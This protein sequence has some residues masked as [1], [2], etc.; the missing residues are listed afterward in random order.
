MN[1]NVKTHGHVF[2]VP[3]HR[4]NRYFLFSY[5]VSFTAEVAVLH[6][7]LSRICWLQNY[8]LS[9]LLFMC[10]FHLLQRLKE[11]EDKF[12][13]ACANAKKRAK[14]K[15]EAKKQRRATHLKNMQARKDGRC[16]FFLMICRGS[17]GSR[18]KTGTLT[19]I[20][21]YCDNPLSWFID[22]VIIGF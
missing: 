16:F 15:E 11:D 17:L 9:W 22:T 19:F 4:Q 21:T 10:S 7:R 1:F 20:V 12:T 5:I 18:L 14:E 3:F 13:K 2:C 8:S 6:C